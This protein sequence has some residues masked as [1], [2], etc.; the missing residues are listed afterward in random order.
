MLDYKT[1][2]SLTGSEFKLDWTKDGDDQFAQ[3]KFIEIDYIAGISSWA[4]NLYLY[5][6]KLYFSFNIYYI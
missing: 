5:I 2:E 1:G 6:F 3:V 4:F